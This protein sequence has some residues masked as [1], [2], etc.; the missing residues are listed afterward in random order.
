METI[1]SLR[2]I[3]AFV[4]VAE[5]GTFSG[6]AAKLGV[7]KSHVSKMVRELERELGVVL[8]VRS[9][10]KVQ[11]TSLGERYL[12]T[13]RRALDAL[14]EAKKE[15]HD[16][17]ATPRGS[18]R[19]TLAGVFGEECIAPVLIEM[20]RKFPALKVEL[21]FSSRM[22]DLIAER[23]DVAIRIGHLQSSTLVAQ[24]IGSRLEYVVCSK[25]YLNA[26]PP[27]RDPSDLIHHNCIGER[28]HWGFKKR[29]KSFQ[30]SVKGNLKSNNPRV[31]LKAAMAG[32]G[33]ARLPGSYTY[34][35]IKKGRLVSMLETFSEGKKDIWIVTPHRHTQNANVRLFVS[36]V[37]KYLSHGFPDGHF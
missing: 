36:E 14:D 4:G 32:L 24:K 28:S 19:V 31:L 34:E 18:L 15:I 7:S 13:C 23:F 25:A 16:F 3:I 2:G 27:L 22:V 12:E 26:N 10:R 37:K 30:V 33:V 1:G 6:A 35:E 17:S 8:L 11:L 29:G 9:T 21:Y 20:A 5:L